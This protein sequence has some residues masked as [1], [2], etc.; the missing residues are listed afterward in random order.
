MNRPIRVAAVVP[1]VVGLG[2]LSVC[3]VQSGVAGTA[4]FEAG[5][6]TSEW[7]FS[8]AQPSAETL[9][10]IAGSL[11]HAR[12]LTPRAPAVHELL[13]VV[14]ARMTS[15]PEY[16]S[17]ADVHFVDAAVLRPTSPYTWANL[18]ALRYGRG[19]TG[20]S[21]EAALRNAAMLGPYESPV[22]RTVANYGLA[23][24]DEVGEKTRTA[25]EGA[26]ANAMKRNPM[27]MLQIADRRGRLAV[28]CRHLTGSTRQAD[29][30]W[31]QLCQ[32]MEATS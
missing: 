28:P 27:E 17:E 1:V 29:S 31:V 13:G 18:V 21:F 14:T 8:G 5:I 9:E 11:L 12:D 20:P 24:W 23:V 30:K 4:V 7:S 25:V 2:W 26:V 6:A 16:A 3:A 15:R 19:D 32:S 22:Q 10:A